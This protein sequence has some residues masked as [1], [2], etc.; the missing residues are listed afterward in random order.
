MRKLIVAIDGPAGAGKSTVAKRVA[1]EM[2]YTYMDTGAMYRAFA[3]RVMKE[4]LDLKN[5]EALRK[6]LRDTRIELAERDGRAQVLLNG[7]DVSGW[8]RTPELSQMASRVSTSKIVRQ[9]MVEL[10]RE[11]GSKGGVV[12]EGRDIGTVVF[13]NAEVKIYLDASARERATR[14]F[15]ELRSR[16]DRVDMAETRGEM[17]QRDRRD[18]ERDVAPLRPAEDAVVIDSTAV[19]VDSVVER[20]MEEIK[21]KL[22]LIH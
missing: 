7:T 5:E 1:K 6:A 2:G 10:Q 4:G 17:E 9:R 19:D 3:W 8:I 13:P 12:A 18:R 21:K 16:G 11:M 20:I 15:E 22:S 14:R